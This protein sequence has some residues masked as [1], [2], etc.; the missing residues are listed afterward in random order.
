MQLYYIRHAQSE[1]N[2]LWELTGSGDSRKVDPDLTELGQQQALY[3][4]QFLSAEGLDTHSRDLDVQNVTGFGITHLYCSLMLRAVQT[5]AE[6][7]R[8]LD[9]P[10]IGWRDLHETGGMFLKDPETDECIGQP[11]RSR[12]FFAAHYPELAPPETVTENGWWNRP[13]EEP[14]E[15][16][17][18]AQRMLSTLLARHRESDDRVALISH[19]GFFYHLLHAIFDWPA[20]EKQW[21]YMS[22]VAITRIDFTPDR[23]QLMYLNRLDFLPRTL[24]SR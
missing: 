2:L 12:A 17:V 7:A 5:G 1:N 4:A 13:F 16:P 20:R 22:N 19:G 21:F 11:G 15:R 14:E 3:L 6:V 24:I 23:T 18:R 8:A 10:L 9:L